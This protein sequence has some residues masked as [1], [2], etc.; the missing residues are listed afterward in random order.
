M[1]P[2]DKGEDVNRGTDVKDY[3]PCLQFLFGIHG[4]DNTT[5]TTT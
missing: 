2:G 1:R 3:A 5:T 4:V